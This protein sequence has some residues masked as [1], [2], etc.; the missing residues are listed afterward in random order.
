MADSSSKS[1]MFATAYENLVA[2]GGLL[3]QI[4]KII[5][6]ERAWRKMAPSEKEQM[7]YQDE[8]ED[9]NTTL[10][11][12]RQREFQEAYLTPAAQIQSLAAGYQSVGINKM[13]LA[14]SQ[15]GAT[16]GSVPQASA[17][18]GTSAPS[19]PSGIG[20][21]FAALMDYQLGNKRIDNEYELRSRELDIENRRTMSQEAYWRTLGSYYGAKTTA[22]ENENS[23]FSI[24]K[25]TLEADLSLKKASLQQIDQWI[26]ESA[27]RIYVN[28][29][30]ASELFARATLHDVQA[31]GQAIQNAIL[32]AQQKY[33]DRYFH[34]LAKIEEANANLATFES[35]KVRTHF[36]KVKEAYLAELEKMIASSKETKDWVNSEAFKRMCE[37][38][39]TDGERTQFWGNLAGGVLRTGLTVAGGLWGAS[40]LGAGKAASSFK[41]PIIDVPNNMMPGFGGYP[42]RMW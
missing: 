13:M 4:Y 12:K 28:N 5:Y 9:E 3:A 41:P 40:I 21:M 24:R 8:I 17:P 10:A 37:G 27:S 42:Q 2:G 25:D 19:I 31:A 38:K 7:N 14:G 11:Y 23:V 29:E 39:M 6:G 35:E 36:T 33:S 22:Q 34:A 1:S 20:D 26:A 30:Q 15:P 16:S 32:E 18:S